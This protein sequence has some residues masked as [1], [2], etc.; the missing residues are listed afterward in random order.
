MAGDADLQVKAGLAI[1]TAR[2]AGSL[3]ASAA[4]QDYGLLTVGRDANLRA[5]GSLHASRIEVGGALDAQAARME[6]GSTGLVKPQD[7][8]VVPGVAVTGTVKLAAD[9]LSLASASIG[10]SASMVARRTWC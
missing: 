8:T 10:Q 6:L 9:S 5:S 1:E 2:V 4:D 3:T 7:D